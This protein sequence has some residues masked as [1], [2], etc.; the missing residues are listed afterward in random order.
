MKKACV[1]LCLCCVAICY[2]IPQQKGISLEFAEYGGPLIP[3]L[4]RVSA[5]IPGSMF[6]GSPFFG[7]LR[8]GAWYLAY[9]PFLWPDPMLEIGARVNYQLSNRERSALYT[10]LGT[11]FEYFDG[12]FGIP[13]IA[14]LDWRIRLFDRYSSGAMLEILYWPGSLGIEA[15]LPFRFNDGPGFGIALLPGAT[16]YSDLEQFILNPRFAVAVRYEFG[17]EK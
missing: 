9:S 15:T 14:N 4:S 7:R 5:E 6:G 13:L 10:G 11:A 2:G 3:T 17:S 8:I 16:L 12:S 1:F